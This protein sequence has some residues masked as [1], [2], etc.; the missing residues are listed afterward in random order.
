[1][2]LEDAGRDPQ[3]PGPEVGPE[4]GPEAGA[5]TEP[6]QVVREVTDARTMRALSH[7]VRIALVEA[8]TF[9][10]PMTATEVGERIGETSTTCSFHLRQLAKYGWVEE[11]GGGKGRARPWRMTSI[12]FAVRS[13]HDDPVAG[14]AANALGGMF[15]ERQLDRYRAWVQNRTAWPREWRDAT[16]DTEC[17]FFLTAEELDRL[18][19]ELNDLVMR[20]FSEERITD[21]SRR[22]PGA[23][24]VEL[25]AFSYPVE[26]PPGSGAPGAESTAPGADRGRD[27]DT[28]GDAT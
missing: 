10:G 20:W 21:P 11:A 27:E 5:G 1:M 25:L 7:P 26:F 3:V 24:P 17:Y 18:G 19:K 4:G 22:P 12:G 28:P 6:P 15:R 13:T 8:L 2:S 23:A 9:G 14:I 16:T